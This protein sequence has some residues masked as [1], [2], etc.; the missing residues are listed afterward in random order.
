[1]VLAPRLGQNH[2]TPK[3]RAANLGFAA[4]ADFG[5]VGLVGVIRFFRRCD[6]GEEFALGVGGAGVVGGEAGPAVEPGLVVEFGEGDVGGVS[7]GVA[8]V[9]GFAAVAGDPDAPGGAGVAGATA[10]GVGAGGED[11]AGGG[12]A[13]G[14]AVGVG[15]AAVE[16]A[17]EFFHISGED[18]AAGIG[19]HPEAV[20]EDGGGGLL[21]DVVEVVHGFAVAAVLGGGDVGIDAADLVEEPAV[22]GVTAAV[23]SAGDSA[24]AGGA[25]DFGVG[26][27]VIEVAVGG[28]AVGVDHFPVVV[29]GA[30]GPVAVPGHGAGAPAVTGGFLK[31]LGGW[32]GGDGVEVEFVVVG[33]VGEGAVNPVGATKGG[34]GTDVHAVELVGGVE[35]V[36]L[37]EGA[38]VGEAGGGFGLIAGAAEGGEEDG[39]EEGDDGN[40]HQ[41]LDEGECWAVAGGGFLHCG[42][43]RFDLQSAKM[44]WLCP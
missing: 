16:V 33:V 6:G 21:F 18:A 8:E 25:G 1:M 7:V 44:A 3:V 41:E 36:G 31:G 34:G 19:V 42:V 20:G 9:G 23:A 37:G 12:V 30:A 27:D 24:D 14:D 5:V 13:V 15:F 43:L 35:D 28:D 22:E 32:G 4:L 39:D 40:D 26:V 11:G 2:G 10:T 17:G 38:D 29:S